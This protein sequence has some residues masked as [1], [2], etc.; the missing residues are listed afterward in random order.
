MQLFGTRIK[1]VIEDIKTIFG[2]GGVVPEVEEVAKPYIPVLDKYES[3]IGLVINTKRN[4]EDRVAT[5][6]MIVAE[7][8]S[9]VY[10]ILPTDKSDT[11]YAW[12]KNSRLIIDASYGSPEFYTMAK[13]LYMNN[14]YSS[15][16][17]DKAAE[18]AKTCTNASK[19]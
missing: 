2:K 14:L 3:C 11:F 12:Y 17:I 19:S 9:A 16:L 15:E 4:T 7:T 13:S 8:D 18:R 1:Q 10:G 5:T 6:F